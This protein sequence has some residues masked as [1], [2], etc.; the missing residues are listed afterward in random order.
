MSLPV[1]D[2]NKKADGLTTMELGK[3]LPLTA[4]VKDDH[5]FIGGCDMVEIAKE[6]GTAL[7]VFD[8]AD[9][10]ARMDEYVQSF[11]KY[12]GDRAEV[13]YAS[14]AFQNKAIV[15]LANEH[16]MC[17]DVSGGG[18]L[19]CAL[20]AGFP[21]KRVVVHGNNKPLKNCVR[22][23][24]PVWGALLSTPVLNWAAFPPLPKNWALRR[25]FTCALLLA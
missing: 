7:Y 3:V 16:G 5:L 10:E 6:F 4:E 25:I 2:L 23:S 15:Q 24:R 20:A 13:A 22:P 17:L 18:E 19:A 14:K 21:A 1:S 8:Q 11:K 9:L 12:Y